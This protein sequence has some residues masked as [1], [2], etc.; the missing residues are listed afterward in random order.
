MAM[1]NFKEEIEKYKPA[2]EIE[3]LE[4]TIS[5]YDTDDVVELLRQITRIMAE[6]E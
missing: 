6:K 2:L 4:E 3:Q 1:I 5:G